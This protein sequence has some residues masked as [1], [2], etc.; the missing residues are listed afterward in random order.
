MQKALDEAMQGRTVLVIAHRLSTIARAK[1]IVV[2]LR[3]QVVEQGGHRALAD[4]EHG[5][6]ARFLKMQALGLEG[7]TAL[8]LQTAGT[9]TGDA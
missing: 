8:D 2:M 1:K 9:G 7:K 6:Y 5:V 3:G 4:R